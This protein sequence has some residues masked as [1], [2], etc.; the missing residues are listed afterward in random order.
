MSPPD[1]SRALTISEAAAARRKCEKTARRAVDTGKLRA[2]RDP[3]SG[4]LRILPED[5]DAW[6]VGE[7]LDAASGLTPAQRDLLTKALAVSA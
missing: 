6:A 4:N 2:Y 3:V 5:V 1:L 7:A